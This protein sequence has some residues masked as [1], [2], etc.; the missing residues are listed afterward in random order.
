M[1]FCPVWTLGRQYVHIWKHT[2]SPETY[3]SAYSVGGVWHDITDQNIRNNL[4]WEATELDYPTSKG[5]PIDRIDIHSLCGG[6]ANLLHL[7]RYS[8]KQIQKMGRW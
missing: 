4:K 1:F 6:G 2:E 3:L 7:N 8:V 5:I